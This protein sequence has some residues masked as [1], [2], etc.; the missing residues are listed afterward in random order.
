M[1]VF[2]ILLINNGKRLLC[3]T[4]SDEW[5]SNNNQLINMNMNKY[6]A[7]YIHVLH[8]MN[9]KNPEIFRR[10]LLASVVNKN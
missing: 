4:A 10:P 1:I 6:S 2:N 5:A 7:E 8:E 9:I 3:F